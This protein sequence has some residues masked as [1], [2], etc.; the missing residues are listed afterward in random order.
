M[1][2]EMD[3]GASSCGWVLA[4]YHALRDADRAEPVFSGRCDIADLLRFD[5]PCL[6][7]VFTY[8]CTANGSGLEREQTN[9][10]YAALSA[11]ERGAG[12]D[13]P[14]AERFPSQNAFW[15]A[16]R[17]EKRRT[18][19][20]LGWRSAPI[21]IANKTYHL[22]YR[23]ALIVAQELVRHAAVEQLQW[24]GSGLDDADVNEY[25]VWS[26]PFDSAAYFNAYKDV[27]DRLP[28]GT[29]VLRLYGY[30]DSTVRTGTGGMLTL[31]LCVVYFCLNHLT[32]ARA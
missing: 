11:V 28:E 7:R 23:D 1:P 22:I 32:V 15:K 18:V 24:D 3:Y 10:F 25:H 29:K 19:E 4:W 9:N 8:V 26:G 30:S 20:A 21:V 31:A 27:T 13:E 17:N 5:T 2:G 14:F 12:G 16:V 6:R